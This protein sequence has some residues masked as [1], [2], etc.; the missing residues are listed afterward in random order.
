MKKII[1][2][3]IFL[4]ASFELYAQTLEDILS[5]KAHSIDA[6]MNVS[7][8]VTKLDKYLNTYM[9]TVKFSKAAK[10]Y[11]V[12]KVAS[13]PKNALISVK[14]VLEG[15]QSYI[16]VSITAEGLKSAGALA[17]VG[18]YLQGIQEN[19]GNPLQWYEAVTNARMGSQ[20]S[21]HAL[22]EMRLLSIR[23]GGG[24]YSGSEI[25]G[26]ID[27]QKLNAHFKGTYL[28]EFQEQH[29]QIEKLAKSEIKTQTENFNLRKQAFDELDNSSKQLKDLVAKNDRA[30]VA[31][32][33]DA[34]LPWEHMEPI[35]V[36]YWKEWLETVKNP[37]P[38]H[39]RI[40][41]YRGLDSGQFFVNDSGKTFLLPP[42]IIKN[43][44]TYNRRLRSLTTMLDKS[45]SKNSGIWINDKS[46]KIIS[47]SSRITNQLLAHASDP[48]GSPHMSFTKSADIASAFGS[49]KIG[50]FALDPRLVTPNAMSGFIGEIELI[51]S[52]AVFPDETIDVIESEGL[53]KVQIQNRAKEI[54]K[55]HLGDT[56]G[57]EVFAR[58]FGAVN[59]LASTE[60]FTLE[61]KKDYL[62]WLGDATKTSCTYQFSN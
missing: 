34:Y 50:V 52:M 43:Q 56:K 48:M 13:L 21:L 55:Q 26:D 33:I 9:G 19:Y 10:V 1:L 24:N 58:E 39:K 44:G 57:E 3:F 47:R 36:N 49:G 40:F 6:E 62:D 29:K 42:V 8:T 60:K 22:S 20:N 28:E 45:I 27:E 4:L 59:P 38:V 25:F 2:L 54:V 30:G 12:E 23:D 46:K 53:S 11:K 35:E 7:T 16:R 41:A 5:F 61:S 32:L 31:K 17:E 37:V 15:G 14:P 51:A 18:R